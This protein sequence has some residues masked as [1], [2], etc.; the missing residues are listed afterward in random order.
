ME[1]KKIYIVASSLSYD[2]CFEINKCF[3]TLERAQEYADNSNKNRNSVDSQT[4]RFY[5]VVELDEID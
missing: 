2:E 4:D 5:F 1:T 3:T